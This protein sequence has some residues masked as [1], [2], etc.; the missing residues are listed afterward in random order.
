MPGRPGSS[1]ALSPSAVPAPWQPPARLDS[2][3][4]RLQTPRSFD[5]VPRVLVATAGVRTASPPLGAPQPFPI[6]RRLP[7]RERNAAANENI[8]SSNSGRAAKC[9]VI[10]TEHRDVCGLALGFEAPLQPPVSLDIG[11]SAMVQSQIPGK[12]KVPARLI[13]HG[14][15][16][17]H[18]SR[19]PALQ[20][21]EER[22]NLSPD[23]A[24]FC[25]GCESSTKSTVINDSRSPLS[26][27]SLAGSLFSPTNEDTF[28]SPISFI[29][30]HS[31]TASDALGKPHDC[32]LSA[33]DAWETANINCNTAAKTSTPM[34]N[35][36]L[37][38]SHSGV[39]PLEDPRH[40]SPPERKEGNKEGLVFDAPDTER[41]HPT[42]QE[43]FGELLNLFKAAGDKV[44][45]E[46]SR[47]S[48]EPASH[49][50]GQEHAVSLPHVSPGTAG[51][52]ELPGS[53]CAI[54]PLQCG[55]RSS[56]STCGNSS[57][58]ELAAPSECSGGVSPELAAPSECFDGVIE[59][60]AAPS[61][62]PAL[63]P[64]GTLYGTMDPRLFPR[65][66]SST[67]T[68]DEVGESTPE[69]N[70]PAVVDLVPG[71]P[72]QLAWIWS[73]DGEQNCDDRKVTIIMPEGVG[74]DRKVRVMMENMQWDLLVPD[75]PQPGDCVT[76]DKPT[77]PPMRSWEQLRILHEE[78]MM[79]QLRWVRLSDDHYITDPARK[80]K[81]LDAY[82]KLRGRRMGLVLLP[83]YEE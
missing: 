32:S 58:Q 34:E 13:W 55:A 25:L 2:G 21:V 59:E 77:V 37:N 51:T 48:S 82:N 6:R 66:P 46:M 50:V 39:E 49:T 80:Q 28:D 11:S 5:D 64:H 42:A 23:A 38:D 36:V 12:A 20:D 33:G 45:E 40:A 35:I 41:R 69:D 18:D 30:R 7:L 52:I 16:D 22:E 53:A 26:P 71:L 79:T 65:L 73:H 74:E 56:A 8:V 78:V 1:F 10:D 14:Q 54:E 70:A 3:P 67:Q 47:K 75:G 76:V 43:S 72:S 17:A 83:L 61:E 81:K 62:P 44:Y 24:S 57:S 4:P 63:N 9:S 31:S 19:P 27:F 60:P 15:G 29:E 68:V